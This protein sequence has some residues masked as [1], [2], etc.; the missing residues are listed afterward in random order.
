MLR[1]ISLPLSHFS[2]VLFSSDTLF[3]NL[4]R[5]E[6]AMGFLFNCAINRTVGEMMTCDVLWGDMGDMGT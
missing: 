4:V 1:L 3:F 2:D 5:S 6:R